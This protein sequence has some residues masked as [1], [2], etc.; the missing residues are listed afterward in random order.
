MSRSSGT[1][2]P[3]A[4]PFEDFIVY[5]SPFSLGKILKWTAVA[6]SVLCAAALLKSMLTNPR[7]EWEIVRGYLFAEPILT[8][9]WLTVWLTAFSLIFGSLLGLGIAIMRLSTSPILRLIGGGYVWFFRGTPLLVQLLFWYNL[10]ALY[11]NIM[12]T[13]PGG[14]SFLNL[15]ANELITPLVAAVVGFTIN[16][17][18]VQ[19]EI[20]RSGIVSV[21]EGQIEAATAMGYSRFQTLTRV[22][23]PQ[24]M[25]VILP[26]T[27]NEAIALLKS[28]SLVSVLTVS[29]LLYSAQSIY[30]RTYEVIP[31]LIVVS[32]WYLLLSSILIWAQGKLERHFGRGTRRN[33]IQ[34]FRI[35]FRRGARSSKNVSIYSP[36]SSKDSLT[37]EAK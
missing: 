26:P 6:L 5:S 29:D 31:L 8:G 32:V 19:A 7:F 11:P 37:G 36:A 16:T 30:A 24:A 14:P 22:T 33:E 13:L 23:L 27:G 25:K 18:S 28:T 10:A 2:T 1:P 35:N 3:D 20:I 34:P 9:L 17:G 12:L 21:E 15:D 4:E